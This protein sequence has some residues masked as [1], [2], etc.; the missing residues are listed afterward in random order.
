MAVHSLKIIG[1]LLLACFLTQ[2][3]MACFGPKLFLGIPADKK[4]QVL[5]SIVAIY[6]KEKTGIDTER[7]SL[8]GRNLL[9]QIV[10]DKLDYGF[11]ES[12]LDGVAALMQVDGLPYLASGPRILEDLQFTTVTPALQR[13]QSKLKP[14]HVE[15]ILEQVKA[16]A[17]PMA[18]ARNFM[19]KQRWI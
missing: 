15:Q 3:A 4:G 13:L 9:E 8:D 6:V 5:T 10:S 14:E 7:V 12:R 19:M 11:A 2:S 1:L 18:A 16:G 17:L